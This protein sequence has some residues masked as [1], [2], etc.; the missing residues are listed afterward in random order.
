MCRRVGP[1]LTAVVLLAIGAAMIYPIDDRDVWWL[2]AAGRYMVDTRSFPTADPFSWSAPG[3]EW[4]NHA[5]AFEL[6]LYGA[7]RLAGTPGL[8]L[9]QALFAL[10]TFAVLYRVLR[11]EGLPAGWA[12][13]GVAVGGLATW[14]FWAPRPQLVTYLMLALFWS[15]LRDLRGGRRDRLGWLPWLT[16]LWANFH[17]GFM[18]GPALIGLCLAG[19]LVDR[20]VRPDPGPR[21]PAGAPWRLAR[22][23]AL[24]LLGAFAT[25]FHYKAVLFPFQVLGDRFAQAF[26]IEWASPGFQHGQIRIVEGLVLLTLVLLVLAPRPPRTADVLVLA[27]FVHFGLQAVRNVPLLVV[28]LL[29][30]LARAAHEVAVERFPELLARSGLPPRRVVA[31]AAVAGLA[32]AVWWTAPARALRYSVPRMAVADIF[33]AG[34]AD[35]LETVRPPG[36]LFNDYGWGGY[37]IWRLYPHYRVSIDGRAAVY[38]PR[39]FAEHVAIEDVRPRWRETLDRSGARLALVPARSALAIVLRVAPDWRVLYED[40]VAVLLGKREPA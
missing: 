7:H 6:V 34:A 3:A 29:P 16:A 12:R 25:P 2:L 26:I 21:A 24:S 4:V 14:G 10:A 18:V 33:P 31:A 38:G 1:V 39:R 40:R 27:A 8:I 9:L 37:L 15:V 5:W 17:G 28:V 11:A 30:V 20:F 19:E 13:V 35:Y 23:G 22:A 36:P 32:F